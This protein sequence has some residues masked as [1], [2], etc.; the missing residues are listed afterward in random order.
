MSLVSSISHVVEVVAVWLD[1]KRKELVILREAIESAE[2]LLMVLRKQGRY[3]LFTDK[4]LHEYEEHYQKRF[5]AW[6][7]GIS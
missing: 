3:S 5:D 4:Q 1:P 2:Q 6:K 7:D